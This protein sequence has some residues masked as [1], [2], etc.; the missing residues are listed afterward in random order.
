[1]AAMPLALAIPTLAL[2]TL[3]HTPKSNS[4]KL[5]TAQYAPSKY[6]NLLLPSDCVRVS[7]GNP[8]GSIRFQDSTYDF[9]ITAENLTKDYASWKR[10]IGHA[11]RSLH[12]D[13]VSKTIG[14][15]QVYEFFG[16]GRSKTAYTTECTGHFFPPRAGGLYIVVGVNSAKPISQAGPEFKKMCDWIAT[17]NKP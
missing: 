4:W 14:P 9:D 5:F 1:M 13:S 11:S 17:H 12:E 16:N 6:V 10:T 7:T 15:F 8:L 2:L 3:T